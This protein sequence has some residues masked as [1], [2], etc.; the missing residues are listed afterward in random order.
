MNDIIIRNWLKSDLSYI[1][2]LRNDILLQDKLLS[3]VKGSSIDD[4]QAWL[5]SKN[6][7]N[8][9][10]FII[11]LK[12]DNKPIGY[13][14]INQ[15]ISDYGTTFG[16]CIGTEFQSNGFGTNAI[17]IIEQFIYEKFKTNIVITVDSQNIF[18]LKCYEKLNY[19]VM[20]NLKIHKRVN[21]IDR[22]ILCMYKEII[23]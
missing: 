23:I 7:L 13:L 19:K 11:A 15:D 17:R 3:E 12:N 1:T 5:E 14:Q 10:I 6:H 2:M 22:N 4:T 8:K 21:G 9:Y 16:I 18:A 20:K